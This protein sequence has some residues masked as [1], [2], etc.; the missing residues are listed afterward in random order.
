MSPA[1][2]KARHAALRNG[3]LLVGAGGVVA[4]L[5]VRLGT[6]EA[7]LARGAETVALAAACVVLGAVLIRSGFLLRRRGGA[8]KP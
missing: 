5:G 3:L 4:A 8:P 1:E 2:E 6:S 7:W